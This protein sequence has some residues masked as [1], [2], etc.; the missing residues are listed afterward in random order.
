MDLSEKIGINLDQIKQLK[1]VE[2]AVLVQRDGNPIQS[3]G[4]WFSKD[5][6]FNVASIACAIFNLG[7]HIH[8]DD[9]KYIL[10]EGK[11]AKILIEFF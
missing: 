6:I 1:G 5:E 10:I 2:C 4:V 8:P 7:I 11:K 9:L 3:C